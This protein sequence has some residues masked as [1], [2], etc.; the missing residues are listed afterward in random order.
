LTPSQTSVIIKTCQEL[1]RTIAINDPVHRDLAKGFG[2][3]NMIYTYDLHF[4]TCTEKK[5]MLDVFDEI[6]F[7]ASSIR[8]MIDEP[9]PAALT[10]IL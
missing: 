8:E 3:T 6:V 7:F 4:I 5:A 2:L 10:K 1:S 9:L